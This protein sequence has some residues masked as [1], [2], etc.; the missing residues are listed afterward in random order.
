MRNAHLRFGRLEYIKPAVSNRSTSTHVTVAMDRLILEPAPDPSR[1]PLCHLLSVFG[2]EQETAAIHAAIADR[3]NFRI[4]GPDLSDVTTNLGEGA[5]TFR[6]L[7]QAPGRRQPVRHLVALS[8][9]LFET[10]AGSNLEADRTVVYSADPD[11]LVYRLSVRFGIP[12]LPC[13]SAWIAAALKARNMTRELPGLGCR[14]VL[15]QATKQA[16]LEM[17]AGAVKTG[18]LQIPHAP[19]LDWNVAQSFGA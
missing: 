19:R 1:A 4:T 12:V 8:H 17:I 14:P 9:D 16:L 3:A 18:I 15:V 13:W 6:G 7:L 2:G 5:H 10:Q 11:F